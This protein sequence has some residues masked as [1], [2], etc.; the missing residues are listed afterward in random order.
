M[1]GLPSETDDDIRGIGDLVAKVYRYAREATPPAQRGG[2]K[3]AVSVST[4]VPKA[5]TPFQWEPQIALEEVRR[6]Q[7]V[8]RESMPRK[9][10]ELH[11]HDA[12]I[13]FLEG[14]MARGGRDLAD[15]IEVA[16]RSGAVFDAW[17]ERFS[18]QRWREAFAETGVDPQAIANRERA[19]DEPLPWDHIS[20]GVAKRYLVREREQALEAATTPDCSFVGCTACDVCQDLGVDIVLG[21]VSRG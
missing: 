1:I 12:D 15:A 13:S 7:S 14:V 2:L 10:V 19:L 9:G 6:R 16:W 20:A 3:I 11:W 21:G 17:T 8:L 4:F 18:V 5:D